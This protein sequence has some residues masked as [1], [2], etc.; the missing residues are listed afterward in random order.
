MEM[1]MDVEY[2]VSNGFMIKDSAGKAV[3]DAA[4]ADFVM[5]INKLYPVGESGAASLIAAATA[6]LALYAF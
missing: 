1:K 6:L 3:H 5:K 2:T 4:G